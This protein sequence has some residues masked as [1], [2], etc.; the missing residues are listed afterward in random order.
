M[1]V[2]AGCAYQ[3]IDGLLEE[4][5]TYVA[6][7][8]EKAINRSIIIADHNGLIHYPNLPLNSAGIDN[9]FIQL[10]SKPAENAY[11]Y[12]ES[13]KSLY[14]PIECNGNQV[15]IIVKSL[16]Q[17]RLAPSLA[18][19]Q[20]AKLAI[21][22]YFS[23]LS[24]RERSK[25]SFEQ[26]LADYLFKPN[27]T[28]IAD[29]L[30]L[31]ES[32]L[33]IHAPFYVSLI[34]ADTTDPALDWHRIGVYCRD[35]FKHTRSDVIPL[36][37]PNG[38]V[39][40]FPAGNYPPLQPESDLPALSNY[41]KGLETRFNL[42]LSQGIGQSYA[43]LD[44]KKSFHEARIALTLSRLMGIKSFDQP[45]SA[46]GVCSLI[47][48][49]EVKVLSDYCQKTL[50]PLT[51]YDRNHQGELL[52]T[53]RQLLDNSFNWKATADSLFI[54]INTLYYRINKIEHLL[55][56]DL[57]RMDTRV[58]LYTAIKIWDTLKCN[59]LLDQR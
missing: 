2:A 18:I 15:Y 47:F 33:D 10:P 50:Y 34:E 1:S 23:D 13:E 32:E 9:V 17:N 45:F 14:Y 30:K 20:E 56:L 53:L 46:L 48:S 38:L 41:K 37:G 51:E 43:L 49:Q 44:L 12:Q 22:C 39:I 5:L 24:K 6:S 19:L 16:S 11:G 28:D 35:Y 29:I 25:P 59:R 42:K 54:H 4:G 7:Y 3:L 58:N 26:N 31:S 27:Q 8:L 57:S 52:A 21:K 40:L 36:T 55:A